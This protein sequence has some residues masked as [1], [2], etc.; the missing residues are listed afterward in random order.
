V[1]AERRRRRS[2]RPPGSAARLSFP[3]RPIGRPLHCGRLFPPVHWSKL[4]RGRRSDRPTRPAEH[5][6]VERQPMNICRT[7]AVSGIV[8]SAALAL[9]ARAAAAE[10]VNG[11]TT[12]LDE[13]I[14][15]PDP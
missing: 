11:P 10:P 14:A 7:V 6:V 12:A 1:G 3:P 9:A 5:P 2:Q 13:Y 8:L 15:K 4:S